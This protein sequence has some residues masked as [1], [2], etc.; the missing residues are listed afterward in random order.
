MTTDKP[1]FVYVTYIESTPEKVYDALLD[2][3]MT[4]LFWGRSRNVSDWKPGSRWQHQSYD[5]ASVVDVEGDVVEADRPNRLVLTWESAHAKGTPGTRVTF[6][7]DAAFGAV[8]LTVT[9]DELP[10]DP[11]L[12]QSVT[13]GWPAILSSLKTLLETGKPMPM[14]TRRWGG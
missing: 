5:D 11:K 6:Q 2:G 9:Q 8:R 14:T 3:E 1:Q 4:K 13:N 12:R 10:A 7:I